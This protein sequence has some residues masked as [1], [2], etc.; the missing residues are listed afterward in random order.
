MTLRN[1]TGEQVE[2]TY[3]ALG[4]IAHTRFFDDRTERYR[5]DTNGRLVQ[6]IAF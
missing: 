6:L 4:G 1:P 3:D 2:S 5:Y